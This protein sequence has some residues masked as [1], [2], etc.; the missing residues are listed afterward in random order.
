[1]QQIRQRTIACALLGRCPFE[2]GY[3]ASQHF[4]KL[5]EVSEPRLGLPELLL[6]VPAAG[7][8]A[9]RLSSAW[10]NQ[11]T[12]LAATARTGAEVRKIFDVRWAP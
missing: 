7:F 3:V 6:S 11:A 1:L 10:A 2:G 5:F 8:G 9:V 4:H 12:E